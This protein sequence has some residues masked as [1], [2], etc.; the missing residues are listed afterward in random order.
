MAASDTLIVLI[1]IAAVVI[2]LVILC[3]QDLARKVPHNYALL[4]TFTLCEAYIVAYISSSYDPTIVSLAM[5]MTVGMFSGLA[6][7]AWKTKSD[8]TVIGASFS[9][10]IATLFMFMMFSILFMSEF[11]NI[12]Y[13]SL[14]VLLFGFYIIVDTQMIIGENRYEINDEDYILG[15]MILYI[16][17][18]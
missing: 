1:A 9:I 8:F 17:I 5:F 7:Y 11:M 12:L 10:F 15:A 18:I 4:A 2:E 3:N 14:C 13:S 6:L 16:D